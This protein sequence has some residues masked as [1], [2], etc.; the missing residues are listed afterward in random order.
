MDA[1][2]AGNCPFSDAKSTRD[3][4][5]SDPEAAGDH[6]LSDTKAAEDR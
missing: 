5:L 4:L 2:V 3:H 1:V 6:P